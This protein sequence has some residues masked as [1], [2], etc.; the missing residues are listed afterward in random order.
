M[1]PFKLISDAAAAITAAGYAAETWLENN[2][3]IIW[4][5]I[6][7]VSCVGLLG[8]CFGVSTTTVFMEVMLP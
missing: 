3:L 6:G 8:F 1:K 7:V 2:Y 4:A 5:V